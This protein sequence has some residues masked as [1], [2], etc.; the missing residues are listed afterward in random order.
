MTGTPP[1]A[2]PMWHDP[3]AHA[4]DFAERYA[5]PLDHAVSQPMMEPGIDPNGSGCPT[6]TPESFMPPSTPTAR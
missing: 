5:E 1:S 6:S 2:R 3:A 4:C